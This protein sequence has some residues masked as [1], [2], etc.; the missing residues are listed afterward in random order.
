[1]FPRVAQCPPFADATWGI[2]S[3]NAL[4]ESYPPHS[5]D[6][7]RRHEHSSPGANGLT[8]PNRD[9]HASV[10]FSSTEF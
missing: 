7:A 1:M 3:M 5:A 2:F 10:T 6:N 9:F 8:G 4:P